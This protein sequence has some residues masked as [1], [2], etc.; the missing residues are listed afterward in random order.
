MKR[1]PRSSNQ[2]SKV[3]RR[4]VSPAP[5]QLEL[6][7]QI[8][9]LLLSCGITPA[10]LDALMQPAFA[11]A[12]ARNARLKNGRVSY[13][14]VA[15]KTGLRRA[16][17]RHLLRPGATTLL[18]PTPVDRLILGWRADS[19]FLDRSGK[20]KLL[21]IYGNKDAFACLA[22]RYARDIPKRA[23]IQELID[24]GLASSRG[25]KLRLH[26]PR[27]GK[28]LLASKAFRA[29]A[30]KFVDQLRNGKT[31]PQLLRTTKDRKI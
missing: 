19:D 5:T 2:K 31:A 26:P 6:L 1:N 15:A 27:V 23:L 7:T 13:S 12:A 21:R 25:N 8:A 17:V 4:A 20:P 24:A 28:S 22:E 3:A 11:Q 29:S 9:D 10:Q 30:L 18:T 14:R 16:S